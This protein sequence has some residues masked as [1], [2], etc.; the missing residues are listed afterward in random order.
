MSVRHTAASVADRGPGSG[1]M[2]VA[3]LELADPLEVRRFA[4]SSSGRH[5]LWLVLVRLHGAPIGQVALSSDQ[6]AG[7]S[8]AAATWR[9]LEPDIQAHLAA[10]G[11]PAIATL[12]ATGISS[13][14][15]PGCV[16]REHQLRSAAPFISVIVPTRD[17]PAQIVRCV[18][19]LAGLDYPNFEIV[20]VDNSSGPSAMPPGLDRHLADGRLRYVFEDVP[21]TSRARNRGAREARGEFVAYVDDDVWI[22]PRW[23]VEIALAFTSGPDVGCVTGA[24]LPAQLETPP[25]RW[26]EEIGGFNKGF[27]RRDFHLREPQTLGPLFPFAAGMFGSG[28]NMAF[29][30]DALLAAGAFDLDLGGGTRLG[31][32]EDLSAFVA[33]LMAGHRI[34]YQPAAVVR[35]WHH[36][37]LGD[38]RR[39]T[40]GYGRGL[41]AHLLKTVIEH[42]DVL[43]HVVRHAPPAVAHVTRSRI[44]RSPSQ[45]RPKTYPRSL[46]LQ[47]WVGLTEGAALY[48]LQRTL[49]SGRADGARSERSQPS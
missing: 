25:Q 42:P 46:D 17:R 27:A 13:E 24:I 8:L 5:D 15:T 36:R 47:W 6:L 21:G 39:Q 23:L 43:A 44:A 29:R 30:R 11:L 31:G 16:I 28:A 1:S 48:L 3:D 18:E 12:D 34:R 32:G 14:S 38:L 37:R 20:V 41:S 33:V 40:R 19:A 35:H 22:D 49:P 7:P 4:E 45:G 9:A 2:G 10:D 26:L